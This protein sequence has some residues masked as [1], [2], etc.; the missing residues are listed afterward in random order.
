[1]KNLY[2]VF[3]L[4]F[5]FIKVYSQND[6]QNANW[7]FGNLAWLDFNNNTLISQTAPPYSQNVTSLTPQPF[8]NNIEGCASV[9]DEDGR[10]LFFT[11]G[12]RVYR[13]VN[14]EI[15]I[16]DYN[17][18]SDRLFGHPSSSQNT[19]IIPRPNTDGRYF[20]ISMSGSL[21][22]GHGLNWSELDIH[23][24]QFISKNIPMSNGVSLIDS[25]FF[26]ISESITSC[27]AN[28]GVDIWIIAHV[29]N[30]S[31]YDRVLSFLVTSIGVSSTPSFILDVTQLGSIYMP[32]SLKVSPDTMRLALAYRNSNPF[33]G[34]FNNLNGQIAIFPT[35]VG[36]SLGSVYSV[37]FSSNSSI[38]YWSRQV[39]SYPPDVLTGI[40]A[41]DLD[42][43]N[44]EF[45]VVDTGTN[46]N[47]ISTLQRGL[48]GRIYA[49]N[50]GQNS[51]F[52][53]DNTNSFGGWVTSNINLNNGNISN[54]GLP[55]WIWSTCK[56]TSTLISPQDDVDNYISRRERSEWINASNIISSNVNTSAIY[57][58]SD[59]VELNVGFEGVFGS[60][61]SGYIEGCTNNFQ[62]RQ[63]KPTINENTINE[64]KRA[65]FI[66]YPNPSST[67][68]ELRLNNF[69]FN[70]ISIVTIDGRKVLEKTL[71]ATNS[72]SL[73]V[74]KYPSGVYIVNVTSLDGRQY[75]QK[76][77]KN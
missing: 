50:F 30:N 15:I 43:P 34:T 24:N 27:V 75:S 26:N 19:I 67:S 41:V 48:D 72:Y 74:S 56:S 13:V 35:S 52:A 58:A 17:S 10:L 7:I 28:N 70:S 14:D 55:Q 69:S 25:S 47:S 6:L 11:D 16:I 22:G 66:I 62:Y 23:T 77:I 60:Q 64:A 46:S 36:N 31:N 39:T 45:Q 71:E 3:L 12:E 32:F 51:I 49:T 61:F 20:L 68:I 54:R 38:L 8:Y 42:N 37:E 2:Y 4:I 76:L 65:N 59:F 33:I 53:I 57:H 21:S 29:K 40:F 1:M 63:Q 9:S 44:T 5:F 18:P 73:D